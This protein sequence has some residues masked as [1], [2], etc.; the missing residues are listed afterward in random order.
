MFH[1]LLNIGIGA[2]GGGAI[3]LRYATGVNA[4]NL[5]V[6]RGESPESVPRQLVGALAAG[7]LGAVGA[8][9]VGFAAHIYSVGKSSQ[10]V[11]EESA[12]FGKVTQT[13]AA[14]RKLNYV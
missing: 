5:A 13:S 2:S 14:A 6:K 11:S 12:Q 4:K 3:G 1:H 10:Q 7:V 9:T 8:A